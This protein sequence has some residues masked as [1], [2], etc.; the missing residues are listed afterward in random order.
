[1]RL[2]TLPRIAPETLRL[3]P[4]VLPVTV[5]GSGLLAAA[6]WHLVLSPPSLAAGMG[7]LALLAAGLVAEAYPVP[8]ERLPAGHMSLAAIFILANAL[9]FGWR[10]AVVAG[11][12]TRAVFEV[13]QRRPLIRLMFNGSLYVLS[14]GAAAG[15]AAVAG[16][17]EPAHWLLLQA[18]VATVAFFLVNIPIVTGGLALLA[19]EPYVA[20]LRRWVRWTAVSFLIMGSVSM[21]LAGSW[22]TSPLL[23]IGLAGPIVAI[24]LYQR[25]MHRALNAIRLALSDPL[26][27]LGNHRH[28]QERLQEELEQASGTNAPVSI[29]LVDLDNFKQIN[30][31]YGHPAGDK[32][33]TQVAANLRQGGDSFRLGGDEFAMLL[34]GKDEAES[35][36]IAE[37]VIARLAEDEC[38]HGGTVSFSAGVATFPQHAPERAELVRVADLALYWAKGE[39]KN[40]VRA[41][42]AELPSQ[43]HLREV[44]GRPDRSSRLEAAIALG[45]AVDARDEYVGSHSQR[46]A[47]LATLVAARMG[48]EPE[49]IELVRVAARLHDLGKLAVPEEILR[50]PGPLTR[51]EEEVVERHPGIGFDMLQSLGID[52]VAE[53]VLH[54]HER[55]D[56]D[57][58]PGRLAGERIPLGS[59]IIFVAD[60][61]DA[62][63]STRP[64]QVARTP[65]EALA[66]LQ[67]GA[68]TQFDP[69]AVAALAELLAH[70]TGLAA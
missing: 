51:S 55:W 29:C 30:D 22:R 15:A 11:F 49:Q 19:R 45:L 21:V 36:S 66:E 58:Y 18:L 53:W 64:Y 27:G 3:L 42:R 65:A 59:R 41:Y 70:D 67:R 6:V 17:H 4:L 62:M 7:I 32:V 33:L 46:V 34:P 13:A 50:K 38:D 40:R 57:G 52:P 31:R 69:A 14:A 43:A 39:G 26:T 28:F 48:L 68:G 47:E 9:I 5:V 56:G 8:V 10:A 2:P 44:A 1:V 24:A 25:S 12:L 35:L 23:A 20:L 63:T 61:Y 60:S 16:P 37:S 54:H